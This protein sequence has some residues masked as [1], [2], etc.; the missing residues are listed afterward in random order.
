MNNKF[1]IENEYYSKKFSP[2]LYLTETSWPIRFIE[3]L[4]IKKIVKLINPENSNRILDVGCGTGDTLIEI[5]NY[6]EKKYKNINKINLFGIDASKYMVERAR[7]RTNIENKIV[8]AVAERLPYESNFFNK[9][10]CSEVL[11]HVEDLEGTLSEISRVLRNGGK[12]VIS[13]PN[14]DLIN[15]MKKIMRLFHLKNVFFPGKYQP[16]MD[17]SD[18]WHKR[19]IKLRVLLKE[20]T[21]LKLRVKK[22]IHLPII[23]PVKYIL[24]GTK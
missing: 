12:Y 22:I 7:K 4:R 6:F 2:E 3:K 1:L 24:Y 9:I 16:E 13:Y 18:H 17:M 20:M 14:E 19:K 11:E 15:L 5:R 10:I 23:F 8:E 21:N